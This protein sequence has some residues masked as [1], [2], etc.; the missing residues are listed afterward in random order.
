MITSYQLFITDPTIIGTIYHKIDENSPLE[1]VY[2]ATIQALRLE[3]LSHYVNRQ[4]PLLSPAWYRTLVPSSLITMSSQRE[5]TTP[6]PTPGH[7]RDYS[8]VTDDA[9]VVLTN[10]S[11]DTEREKNAEKARRRAEAEQK[12]KERKA[13]REQARR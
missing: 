5:N 1:L 7:S 10:D 12:E 6:Q 13:K 2:H 9:L 8:Q 11:T 3:E 4:N